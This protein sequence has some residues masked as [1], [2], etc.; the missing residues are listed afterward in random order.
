MS[1]MRKQNCM[2]CSHGPVG[3]LSGIARNTDLDRPQA[4]GYNVDEFAEV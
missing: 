2:G 4:G 3:R 1:G